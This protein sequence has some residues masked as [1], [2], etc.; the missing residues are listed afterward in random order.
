MCCV[1]GCVW[2]DCRGG[3]GWGG[4]G[5]GGG[6]AQATCGTLG[7]NTATV[8]MRGPDGILRISSAT[9]TG[10]PPPLEPSTS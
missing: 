3:G 9:G 10:T 5:G 7:L 1:A 4:D 6:G 8:K 2:K